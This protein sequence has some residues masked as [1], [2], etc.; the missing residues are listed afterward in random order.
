MR[1]FTWLGTRPA[2]WVRWR[3]AVI[4]AVAAGLVGAG[5]R[6]LV[7]AETAAAAGQPRPED[8]EFFEAKVRPLLV[9][10]CSE[11]HSR[12]SGDPEGG[13]SFDSRADFLAAEGVAVAGRPEESLIVKVVRYDGDLQMPPDGKLPPA[14]IETITEWVRRGLP[15]PADAASAG[16]RPDIFD[17]AARKSAHWCW[18]PPRASPPPAVKDPGWC[19]GD[20]DR[21]IL[22]RL[23]QA[24]LAPAPEAPRETLARRASEILTGLPADP[25][26]VERLVADPDP[27]AFEKYVD[28]LL[29]SPHFGERFARHWLDVVRYGETRGHEFDFPLPNA[30]RYRDWVIAAFNDDLPYDQ[31]VRE[32]IA[33]DLLDRPRI[34]PKSGANL[35]I[36]GT[37]FWFLG[38]AVHAP[39]DIAQDEADRVDN[40]VDTFGKAFLGLALGCARCHDHK[41]DAISN[42]DY[43]AIAGALMSSGYRQVPFETLEHNR[44]VAARLDAAAGEARRAVAPLLAAAAGN[45]AAG[46][47]PA[48]PERGLP[49]PPAREP[50]AGETPL[51]D[52]TRGGASTPVIA[53]GP[54][55]AATC[56]PAGGPALLPAVDGMPRRLRVEPVGH[57]HSAAVWAT[58]KSTGERDVAPLGAVDRA[59]RV[60]RTP[61]TLVT[62]GVLWHRVRGNLQVFTV[63]DGHVLLSGGPLYGGHVMTVD[64][65]GEWQWV[66]QDLRRDLAWDGGRYVHV[67]YAAIAGAADVAE[68]V[69]AVEQPRREDP[70]Q[71]A[72]VNAALA[73]AGFDW[74][75]PAAVAAVAEALRHDE[76]DR[77]IAADARLESATALAI[78]DGNG[79][80]RHVMIKGSAARRGELSPR[81]FLEAIDGPDQPAWPRQS[82]GRRE[83]AERVLDPA[84]PLTGRVMVNRVWHHLFGRG[85][86]AT[87][88]N[89]GRL[90]E[91]AA[92]P[93]AQALLDTL[94]VKFRHEGASVKRLVREIVTSSAWRMAGTRDPRA[95]EK[96]PLDLL[97]HHHPLRRLEGEAIRDKM[98]A[99]S[100]RLDR[101]VGGPSV[102]VFLTD[103]QH[104]RG[105]P[106]AGPL[107]GGGRRSLYTRI[108]RNFL[109][110]FLLAFDLPVPFQAMGRRNVTNVPA[111]ALTLMNDPFVRE[112]ATLWARKTLADPGLAPETRIERMYREAFARPPDAAERAAAAEFLAAQAA[113]HGV[114]FAA[115][116]RHEA[117]WADFAQALFNSKEFIFVP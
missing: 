37:G 58:T 75:A 109:P 96:D 64:T 95:A 11:C 52:Y 47:V 12:K 34:D 8:L 89:F 9:E 38:E 103:F 23:E 85:L 6:G 91:A 39:V 104:G 78:L 3:A 14:A 21:F 2:G 79:V 26:E 45:V 32:Q 59:G 117:T 76:I 90:G 24:G 87:T 98:L 35:S 116:P 72:A 40:A 111:Q 71:P 46:S 60:L 115:D 65:K 53:D 92:D 99:V 110:S 68:T 61:K 102:E 20:I 25:A 93:L 84:N 88:D 83:L 57:A 1:R 33:G 48:G 56:V 69:A 80:D 18:H 77:G 50:A 51:A 62:Q 42:E 94:A 41:F 13:L 70:P 97:L 30:W 112:Q 5:A 114:A 101:T 19:R 54:A 105:R 66:R 27:Q 10:H 16:P 31:F 7:A 113:L 15:W 86:V 82:S 55:W 81:R 100:G 36:V 17:I 74:S 28:R 73:A 107:D 106:R 49:D 67:E 108:R 63:V 22:A 29:A 4:A 43:Y 44:A